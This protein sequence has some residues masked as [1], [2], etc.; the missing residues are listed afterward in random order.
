MILRCWR[1]VTVDRMEVKQEMEKINAGI[2]GIGVCLPERVL[3]ND[4]LEKLVDTSDAWIQERTGIR[5]RR[6]AEPEQ[7]ASDLGVVAA[8]RALEHSGLTP[9][10]IDLII[11]A[12]ATPDMQFPAT[13][14]L[15][16]ERLGLTTTPAF[17]VAAGCTGFIYALTIGSQFI[18]NGFYQTVLV[19]GAEVLSKVTNWTDRETCILLADGAGAVVLRPV[20]ANQGILAMKLGADGAGGK[21]LLLPAGGSRLPLTP[22]G[23]AKNLHKLHMNGQEV[24]KFAM[25]K[26][27]E[28]TDQVLELAGLKVEDVALIVPHQA[29][30]RIIDAAARR[31]GLPI[32][33]FMVNLDRYGNTSSASIP[34]ALQEALTTQRI[35]AGDLLVLTGFGAGL[36]WGAVAMRW[37]N[38]APLS[39]KE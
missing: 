1:C 6:I 25:K 39:E 33:K 14:C 19:I 5:E 15:I 4:E 26:L 29:N 37:L 22:E 10:E 9:Q 3:T 12:T 24:F 18:V 2:V 23:L 8:R 17:D 11:V 13:A 20:P 7:A 32:D 30:L 34:I 36:T 38:V 35:R 21:D 16:A 28:V 27:P 31:M